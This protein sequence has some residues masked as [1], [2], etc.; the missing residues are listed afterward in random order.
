MPSNTE[1][2]TRETA[3]RARQGGTRSQRNFDRAEQQAAPAV[4]EMIE[5]WTQLVRL[6]VPPVLL[7]PESAL[8]ALAA[9]LEQMFELQRRVTREILSA[10]RDVFAGSDV[11]RNNNGHARRVA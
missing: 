8:R 5:A 10:S 4:E 1:T 2:E 6:F 7:Q 11:E 9:G 3:E